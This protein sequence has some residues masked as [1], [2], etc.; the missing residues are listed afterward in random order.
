MKKNSFT[1][2][3]VMI[4]ITVLTLAVG[5][6]FALVQQTLI[7]ASSNQSKLIAHYLAQEGIEIVKNIRDSN[8]LEQRITPTISWDEGL[9][10]G[11]WE[12]DYDDEELTQYYNGGN[13]LNIDA[14]GFY[15]Y[16]LGE[17]TKFK[18]KIIISDKEDLNGD[19]KPDK[20]KITIQVEFKERGRTHKIETI[21]YL[22]NW[23]GY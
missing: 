13:F 8:W 6:S 18:R 3:E 15:S 14:N 9:A 2:L 22:Y 16:S 4:A 12:A 7:A 10:E 23:Y 21:E 17:E 20:M 19:E 11:E 5:G 1:L